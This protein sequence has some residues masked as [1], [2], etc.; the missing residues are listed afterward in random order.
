MKEAQSRSPSQEFAVKQCKETM[1][2]SADW[3]SKEKLK[4]ENLCKNVKSVSFCASYILFNLCQMI[5]QIAE[6]SAM[7]NVT[8]TFI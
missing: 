5:K 1:S 8:I 2:K 3:P 7:L 6:I 4:L